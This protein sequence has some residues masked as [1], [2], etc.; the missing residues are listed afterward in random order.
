MAH[1]TYTKEQRNKRKEDRE[2]SEVKEAATMGKKVKTLFQYIYD[3][4]YGNLS[5]TKVNLL[6]GYFIMISILEILAYHRKGIFSMIVARCWLLGGTICL[7]G[8][9]IYFIKNIGQELKFRHY[10]TTGAVIL[11]ILF[12]FTLPGNL[13]FSD[14]N[15]DA[16]QQAAAGLSSF[17]TGDF[18]YTGKAFLEYPNRQYLLAALPALFLGR[19]IVTLHMGF[20]LPFILGLLLLYCALRTWAQRMKLNTVMAALPIFALFV[21]PYVT[22]YY[23][24]FEQA[25]Y[26]ISFTMLAIGFFLLF[27]C[28]PN[29]IN[30]VGLAWGGGIFS[31]SYTPAL[32]ALGLMIVFLALTIF[33]FLMKPK[34]MPFPVSS[35]R[36]AVKA[37]LMIE[38]NIMAFFLAT[39]LG[40][41]QDKLTEFRTDINYK[42]L[43]YQSLIDFLTD[44]NAV[45]FGMFGIIVIVYL[46]ASLIFRLKLRN[47]LIALW[48]L[49]V[50]VASNLLTGY[51]NYDPAW[52]MQRALIIIPV[53][54]TAVTLAA[55]EWMKKNNLILRRSMVAVII[56]SF[57]LVGA[58]NFMQINQSFTYFNYIQPM[59]YMWEDLEDVVRDNNLEAISEFNLILYTDSILMKNPADYSKFFYPNAKVYAPETGVFPKDLDSSLITIIYADQEIADTIPLSW[60]GAESFEDKRYD[61][62]VTW[63]KGII[64]KESLY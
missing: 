63:Y 24:N 30:I 44:K 23:T 2:R 22:E 26:P 6:I 51:I 50:I 12:L 64:R 57:A 32:A 58:Y 27:L 9:L 21:F 31:N 55:F 60:E 42:K 18:N 52:I 39:L 48:I 3:G 17:Q 33:G 49:G 20:G 10:L 1:R 62:A 37:L 38:I 45:F 13:K 41:R 47:F 35:P 56:S 15:Q 11:L 16:T 54:I 29:V 4:L 25:I 34:E 40:Q 7:L 53:I 14:I 61:M 59:K 19:S 46:L 28:E 8:I 36:L 5:D 43:I